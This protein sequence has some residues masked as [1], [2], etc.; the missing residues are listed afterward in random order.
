MSS[1]CDA[2]SSAYVPALSLN[3]NLL[4]P[5]VILPQDKVALTKI[6]NVKCAFSSEQRVLKAEVTQPTDRNSRPTKLPSQTT[7]A[8]WR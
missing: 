8:T 3:E 5:I 7:S 6:R 4:Q 1:A 2:L